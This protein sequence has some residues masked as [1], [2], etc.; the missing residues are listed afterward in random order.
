MGRKVLIVNE[1]PDLTFRDFKRAE[2]SSAKLK[3]EISFA[4][5]SSDW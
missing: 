4:E 1:S 5:D 3:L 2:S